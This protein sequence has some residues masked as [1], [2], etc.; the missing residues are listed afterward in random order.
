MPTTA[1][2]SGSS[3]SSRSPR[4]RRSRRSSTSKPSRSGTTARRS[5]KAGGGALTSTT[6]PRARSPE[7]D[8]YIAKAAPFARP[9]LERL[10]AVV[11]RACPGVVEAIKWGM[12]AFEY[13]GPFAGM[14]AFKAHAVFGFWKH[15]LLD[16]PSGVLEKTD[17][18]AMGNFGCLRAVD[19]L[20][21]DAVL[22]RLV[23]AAAKLNDDGVK[24]PRNATVKKSIPM[25]PDFAKALRAK[26]KA[27]AAFDAFSPSHRREYLEW[28]VE[29]KRP[30]TRAT[31][32]ATALEW[33]AAGKHR[34]WKYETKRA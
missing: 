15:A 12:P 4:S 5:S 7:V 32:I 17:R 19:D 33:L 9:I 22:A 31:R 18:T 25:P 14:A 2:R 26:P 24:L 13:K 3:R 16:D 34:N 1:A 27:L 23:K 21:S 30:E 8:A 29:A 20:P 28:I 11:H 6:A 10:R